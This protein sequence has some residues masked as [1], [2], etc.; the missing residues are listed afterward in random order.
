MSPPR[1]D[2]DYDTYHA[3]HCARYYGWL[4]ASERFKHAA[5]GRPLK[6][7]TLCG[8]KAIDVFMLEQARVLARD[9]DGTLPNVIVCEERQEA[10]AQIIGVVRPPVREAVFICKI[11]EVLLYRDDNEVRRLL[12]EGDRARPTSQQRRKIL[13]RERAQ[14]LK[15]EFPFDIINFDPCESLLRKDPRRNDLYRAFEKLFELQK[16]TDRFLLLA[17][18]S[19]ST[20]SGSLQSRFRSDLRTNVNKHKSVREVLKGSCGSTDYANLSRNKKLAVGFAKSILVP[21]AMR[22]GWA[23]THKGMY[24]YE[25]RPQGTRMLSA[26][27]ELYQPGNGPRAADYVPDIVRVIKDMARYF[28][29]EAAENDAKVRQHLESITEYRQRAQSRFPG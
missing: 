6:Y 29:W 12:R 23:C 4:P 20:V 16:G 9:A 8:P 21:L 24:V 10:A 17:T 7:F 19:T 25:F 15:T 26:V 13:L 18:M 27:V 5:Q 1:A 28:S 11:E 22:Q 2:I 14:R 3:K